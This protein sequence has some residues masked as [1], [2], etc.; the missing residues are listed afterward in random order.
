[1]IAAIFIVLSGCSRK[2]V[3]VMPP[4]QSIDMSA[5]TNTPVNSNKPANSNQKDSKNNMNDTKSNA[6]SPGNWG[7]RGIS[8][9]VEENGAKIEYDCAHGEIKEKLTVNENGEF[10]ADGTH[11]RESFGPIIQGKEPKPQ[12][13]HYTGKI[14]GDTMTLKV[15][16]TNSNE[17]VGDFT[18]GRDKYARLTKCL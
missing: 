11:T 3:P 8:V 7:A 12:P 14:S 15:T 13:A 16:L 17:S 1:M 9:L 2:N 18:L 5:P 10:E 6:V 4:N